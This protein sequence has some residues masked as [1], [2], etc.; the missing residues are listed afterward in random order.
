MDQNLNVRTETVK[1]LENIGETL[2]EIGVSDYFLDK[3]PKAQTTKAKIDKWDYIKS[4][5]FCTVE[6]TINRT[7]R[8]LTEL[9]KLFIQQSI[10]IQ[11]I[12]ATKKIQRQKQLVQLRNGQRT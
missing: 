10:N 6:E 3:T 11:N 4:R 2:Q 12:T 7:K 5:S 8:H 9:E 1:F